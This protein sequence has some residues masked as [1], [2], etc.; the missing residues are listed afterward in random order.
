MFW[1]I[2]VGRFRHLALPLVF[3]TLL[4]KLKRQTNVEA[5]N[6]LT[7]N[8]YNALTNP[9]NKVDLAAPRLV[10]TNVATV[11]IVFNR[12]FDDGGVGNFDV[13]DPTQTAFGISLSVR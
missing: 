8:P 11:E 5:A 2:G 13:H 10:A 9:A 1:A 3:R 7:A 12:R 4:I 6:M